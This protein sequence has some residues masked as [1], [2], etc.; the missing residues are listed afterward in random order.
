MK[1]QKPSKKIKKP[2]APRPA[3]KHESRPVPAFNSLKMSILE[4]PSNSE[5]W[6]KLMSSHAEQGDLNAARREAEKALLTIS[7]S[8]EKDLLNVWKSF[9]NLEHF[10]GD[11]ESF[12]KVFKRALNA[13]KF[14]EIISH[15]VDLLVE[16]KKFLEAE[17]VIELNIKKSKNRFDAWMNALSF[18]VK[19]RKSFNSQSEDF[20]KLDE[21]RKEILRRALQSLPMKK[22]I[23]FLVKYSLIEYRAN[24][25]E[26]ARSTF[27]NILKNFPK[28]NDIWNVFI[29]AEMKFTQDL[30]VIRGLFERQLSLKQNLKHA[31][32]IFKKFL[33]F[34]EKFGDSESQKRV[35]SKAEKFVNEY[36]D[37]KK[38][39]TGLAE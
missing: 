17:E 32:N 33:A 15:V 13:C 7:F 29:D 25:F 20:K 18:Y 24:N 26:V 4:H 9:I 37:A 36:L 27:E 14:E 23:D 11:R 22:H 8:S 28:R 16:S 5:T 19:W 30:E 1:V 6:V 2:A 10:Y 34:E 39:L 38:N 12:E 31:Q 35:T 21:K 3:T